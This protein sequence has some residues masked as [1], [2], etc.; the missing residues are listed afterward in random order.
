MSDSLLRQRW[1]SRGKLLRYPLYGALFATGALVTARLFGGRVAA[2]IG[3]RGGEGFAH[4]VAAAQEI[5][6][7]LRGRR[8]G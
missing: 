6:G 8:F 3:E 4:G 2:S 1:I 5:A 7:S